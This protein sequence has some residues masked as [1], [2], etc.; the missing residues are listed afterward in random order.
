MQ[1]GSGVLPTGVLADH[2]HCSVFWGSL[3]WPW[4]MGLY[5]TEQFSGAGCPA[6]G[7]L[8]FGASHINGLGCQFISFFQQ[9]VKGW[10]LFGALHLVFRGGCL[11][12]VSGLWFLVG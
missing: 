9:L 4:S 6:G 7:L 8:V 5:S 11:Q 2:I 1:P 10:P 3:C 12:G